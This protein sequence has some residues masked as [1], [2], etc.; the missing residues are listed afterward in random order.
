MGKFRERFHSRLERVNGNW[1][2]IRSPTLS[3]STI[4]EGGCLQRRRQ[5]GQSGSGNLQP[6]IPSWRVLFSKGR[7]YAGASEPDRFTPGSSIPTDGHRHGSIRL[8]LVL[9]GINR[10]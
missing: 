7:S 3:S 10:G 2:Y 1:I 4:A 9:A 8:G 6:P 5:S